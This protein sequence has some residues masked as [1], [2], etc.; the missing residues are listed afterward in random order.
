MNFSFLTLA[1]C[2]DLVQCLACI[3]V[4]INVAQVLYKRRQYSTDGL[5]NYEVLKTTYRW[6]VQGW[7]AILLHPVLRYPGYLYLLAIQALAAFLLLSHL[8][9]TWSL[10]LILLILVIHLLSRLREQ[11]GI[12][13][14]DQMQVII[15]TCLAIFYLSPDPLVK[16][17]CMLFICFQTFLAYFTGGAAKLLSAVWR[18]GTAVASILNTKSYGMAAFS[19]VLLEHAFLARLLC[20]ST[21]IFECMFP[22]LALTDLRVC[23]FLLFAGCLFH[24]ATALCM[25]LNDFVWTFIATYPAVLYTTS[26]LQTGLQT[27][28]HHS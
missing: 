10:V 2:A 17:C 12:N 13:G 24:I 1:T 20:W 9:V 5:Y 27:L 7:L 19:H 4:I 25:G 23:L 14:S 16:Q 22:L 21:I 3:P 6:L 15:F 26:A 18:G 28:F 11:F 8:V